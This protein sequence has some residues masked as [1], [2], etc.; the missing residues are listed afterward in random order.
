MAELLGAVAGAVVKLGI[1]IVEHSGF[2][3]DLTDECTHFVIIPHEYFAIAPDEPVELYQRTVSFGVEHPGTETFEA[4]VQHGARL[5]A[6]MEISE[7]SVRELRKR[8]LSA[9]HFQ[10][11]YSA[12]WDHWRGRTL[13]RS[14]DVV[15]LGTADERRCRLLAR[16]AESLAECHTELVIPPHEPMTTTHQNF[17][18]GAEKWK[19]LSQSKI[20]IN[21]HRGEKTSFELVRGLEAMTNGCVV[22]TETSTDLGPL[23]PGRH[24]LMAPAERLSHVAMALLRAPSRLQ[25]IAKQAYELISTQLGM[26]DSARRLV[27]VAGELPVHR[28]VVRRRITIA[29]ADPGMALWIP[30]SQSFPRPTGPSDRRLGRRIAMLTRAVGDRPIRR[31]PDTP[32]VSAMSSPGVDVICV[33][34]D[35]AG[36]FGTTRRSMGDL[37]DD[38]P[39]AVIRRGLLRSRFTPKDPACVEQSIDD[40]CVTGLV[41]DAPM[42]RG[43]MRNLLLARSRADLILVLDSGDRLLPGTLERLIDQLAQDPA[44]D[45]AFCMATYGG[46]SLTNVLVPEVRRLLSRPYLTRGYLVRRRWL[47]QLGGFTEDPYLDEFVDHDFWLRTAIAGGHAELVRRI[48]IE[49][50]P[51]RNRRFLAKVDPAGVLEALGATAGNKAELTP[52]RSER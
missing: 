12:D 25:A 35:F 47:D 11:G 17:L 50:F 7:A 27:N 46:E 28:T 6:R 16:Y 34:D 38:R 19:L 33:S 2:I 20:M 31:L 1:P 44:A 39:Q 52:V 32:V 4:S 48:G 37:G 13:E 3:S 5:G 9:E 10:L 30:S 41:A 15:Y 14:V 51:D 45:V 49:L 40:R 21:L 29:R 22:V 24:L 26:N 42:A 36:P 23:R 8:G 18:R 43:R